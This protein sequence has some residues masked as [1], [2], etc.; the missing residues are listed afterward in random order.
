[1]KLT[2]FLRRTVAFL[3][4][5][6]MVFF[7]FTTIVTQNVFAEGIS[8]ENMDVYSPTDTYEYLSG[9]TI[10]AQAYFSLSATSDPLN[11]AQWVIRIPKKYVEKMSDIDFGDI[12]N[13]ESKEI[14]EDENDYIIIYH[15]VPM[16]A[17]TS[18]LTPFSFTTW[19][20]YIA[21][22][23]Q[24]PITVS[25][26]D[27]EGNI[28]R[29]E[30][31]NWTITCEDTSFKKTTTPTVSQ[32][33]DYEDPNNPG[34]FPQDS[35]RYV[36][37]RFS[38]D[39]R[40]VG[41]RRY[42]ETVRIVD[43]LPTEARFFSEDND[44]GWTYDESTHT[45]TYEGRVADSVILRLRFPGA[46]INKTY[47]NIAEATFHRVNQES[48]EQEL[49]LSDSVSIRL[50]A[51]QDRYTANVYKTGG[52]IR[53]IPEQ[54]NG[55]L[56]YNIAY[57][58]SYISNKAGIINEFCI[59]DYDLDVEEQRIRYCYA[60][61][62]QELPG[63]NGTVDVYALYNDGSRELV[64]ANI[65]PS[66]NYRVAFP[67]NLV[68]GEK[69]DQMIAFEVLLSA[70]S[71]IDADLFANGSRISFM[72]VGT[73]LR[74]KSA[75]HAGE[76]YWNSV[77]ITTKV[78]QNENTFYHGTSTARDD[79]IVTPY[80][81][82][83][84]LHK[85]IDVYS[86]KPLYF[87]G[88]EIEF[89]LSA[90]DSG[91]IGDYT[92]FKDLTIVDLLPFGVEY[93]SA[94]GNMPGNDLSF[95]PDVV[96]N[97]RN[98][99]RTALIWDFGDCVRGANTSG[100]ARTDGL[101]SSYNRFLRISLKA[102][103][104]SEVEE[105]VNFN[106]V[107]MTTSNIDEF[108]LPQEHW[109]TKNLNNGEEGYA[110]TDS[111]DIDNDGSTGDAALYFKTPFT[112]DPPKELLL[113]KKVKGGLNTDYAKSGVCEV[114]GEASYKVTAF[115]NSISDINS[116]VIMDLLPSVGD[117]TVSTNRT[118]SERTE[119]G[120]EFPVMIS[121]EIT[122]SDG[123]SFYYTEDEPSDNMK[124]FVDNATWVSTPTAWSSV[125]AFKIVM[126][127]GVKLA[128]EQAVD[129]FV[130][131]QVPNVG[132]ST[133][134]TFAST[135]MAV[136]SF[137]TRIDSQSEFI[138]SNFAYLSV[139]QNAPAHVTLKGS[140]S[141]SGDGKTNADITAGLFKFKLEQDATNDQNGYVGFDGGPVDVQAGGGADSIEFPTIS[142]IKEGTYKFFASETGTAPSG[143]TYDGKKV[144]ITVDV[145]AGAN[146][147]LIA[148]VTYEK[149][150]NTGEYQTASGIEFANIYQKPNAVTAK[151]EGTKTLKDNTGA[152][153]AIASNQFSVSI[154][155]D[156]ANDAT[157]YTGFTAGTKPVGTDGTWEFDEIS[158]T[159][160]GTYKFDITEVNGG[161]VGYT[162]DG[163]TIVAEV[164]V[165]LDT[166]TNTLKKTVTCTVN[167][168]EATPV[169]A[170]TYQNP[171]P[172][173]VSLKGAKEMWYD[174]LSAQKPFEDGDFTFSI[175][176]VE[177]VPAGL[178]AVLQSSTSTANASGVIDFGEITFLEEGAYTFEIKE[179]GTAPTGYSYDKTVYRAVITVTLDPA[180][181]ML[182]AFDPI[183]SIYDPSG[184]GSGISEVGIMFN[185][186][187]EKP[188]PIDVTISGSKTLTG[189]RSTD[190]IK[191]GDFAFTVEGG[192]LGTIVT[193]DI[194]AGGLIDFPVL[195]FDEVGEYEFTITEIDEGRTGYTYDKESVTVKV[196]VT[197]NEG[198]NKLEA[199]VTY[200]KAGED[201]ESAEFENSY[202]PK[203]ISVDPPVK[204]IVLGNP[205]SEENF[206]FRFRAVSNTAGYMVNE[207]P[208][209]QGCSG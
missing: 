23:S 88:D 73:E 153:K 91:T 75:S 95:E 197:L 184:L 109:Y 28:L 173:N 105:G 152:D 31:R 142:F 201:A 202:T 164:V 22:G 156:A 190:D 177:S 180:D 167:G 116:L 61:F 178:D 96:A 204:K 122:G 113:Y 112:Y 196:V 87:Q 42:N 183:I 21:N 100:S 107:W 76:K 4:C 192:N 74:D 82:K 168:D 2:S 5:L 35:T 143:Y 19:N 40:P 94:T 157:G 123:F 84:A 140:K 136:N 54:K 90:I 171:D 86:S 118:T 27:S 159:K 58:S 207:M 132:P 72:S 36:T 38:W 39:N 200:K 154:A 47:T 126:N 182:K 71:T 92:E 131:V 170:N 141:L 134:G 53:D 50:D 41:G 129:F 7:G 135:D 150:D 119:R 163:N 63:L 33:Y 49:V 120:S 56:V 106:E 46:A 111:L 66:A 97:Y 139:K 6:V 78:V 130:P 125:K 20:G 158:F 55:Y 34:F 181:N 57:N 25:L 99:G 9:R 162:Y 117:K 64:E 161:A 44:A 8:V 179:T 3:V 115:N 30:S 59:K 48:W 124:D 83:L 101:V 188:E 147:S 185:N 149:Q 11:D 189:Q 10:N 193:V 60:E 145:N 79:F 166:A 104:T 127:A 29:S 128:P 102:R 176:Q 121:G 208:M 17:T 205:P 144:R 110:T 174:D 89:Q 93:I 68:G 172:I 165:S 81:P 186:L 194:Q 203:P 70:G 26:I 13:Q 187:Y 175:E 108:T 133:G 98:T 191:I 195:T 80:E 151:F 18:I 51:Q 85:D 52:S 155:A 148:E 67:K 114:G 65:T 62:K 77:Q 209:P 37:Y 32:N 169:F 206:T 160:I 198:T 45:A 199:E 12:Q 146:D 16:S 103:I 24:V 1:M 138:E 43:T 137:G 69:Q 15:L 14:T